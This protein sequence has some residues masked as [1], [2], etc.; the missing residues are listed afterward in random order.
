MGTIAIKKWLKMDCRL[1]IIHHAQDRVDASNYTKTSKL[2]LANSILDENEYFIY[3]K[4]P[5]SIC[6]YLKWRLKCPKNINL[7]FKFLNTL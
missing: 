5:F 2:R 3:L 1:E 6:R 4:L 7:V